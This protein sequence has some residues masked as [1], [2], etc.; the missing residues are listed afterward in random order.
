MQIAFTWVKIIKRITLKIIYKITKMKSF[1]K[2]KSFSYDVLPVYTLVT[3]LTLQD[4]AIQF[5]INHVLYG[6]NNSQVL[7]KQIATLF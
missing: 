2:L 6:W 7:P 3:T 1:E 5:Y 4:Q